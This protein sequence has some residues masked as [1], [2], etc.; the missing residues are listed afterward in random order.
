[1]IADNEPDGGDESII[2]AFAI[3]PLKN[4]GGRN[5]AV[6]AFHPGAQAFSS[7]Y[8]CV[9]RSFDNYGDG[10]GVLRRFLDQ[11]DHHCPGGVNYFAY[12]GHGIPAGLASAHC[13]GAHLDELIEVLR[14]KINKPLVII[15]YACSCGVANAYTNKLRQALGGQVWV[16]GHTTVGHSYMN[17]QVSEESSE[18]SPTY[19]LMYPVGHDLRGPWADALKY[20]DLWLRFPLM[21]DYQIDRELCGRRLMGKWEISGLGA[22]RHYQFDWK[23][24]SWKEG[25]FARVPNGKVTLLD[26]AKPSSPRSVGTWRIKKTLKVSWDSGSEETWRLPLKVVGQQADADGSRLTARRVGR[27]ANLG[28][29]QG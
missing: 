16:Y 15:L 25:A 13:Y 9:S 28:K 5:D 14:P 22:L 11:I 21:E 1:M 2:R 10:K 17:P 18:N 4:T 8:N 6:G 24:T 29:L 12:F 19:R 26:P 3:A 20:T 7:A 23:P 27:P